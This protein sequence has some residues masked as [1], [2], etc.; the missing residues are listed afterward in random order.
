M[1]LF[2]VQKLC[3]RVAL[4]DTGAMRP[5]VVCID[6]IVGSW[7]GWRVRVGAPELRS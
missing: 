1:P 3:T 6:G 5:S 4:R 7:S 2:W